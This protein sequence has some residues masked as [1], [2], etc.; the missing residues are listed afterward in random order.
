[1]PQ[2]YSLKTFLRKAC[3]GFLRPYRIG[4]GIGQCLAQDFLVNPKITPFW[5]PLCVKLRTFAQ[6]STRISETSVTQ[7]PKRLAMRSFPDM[8]D[9]L[10]ILIP[11]ATQKS[12]NPCLPADEQL[13]TGFPFPYYSSNA[14]LL[15]KWSD[16]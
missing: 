9:F 7:S 6:K 1:M 10:R 5:G 13:P 16:I 3:N 15:I 12:L 14:I 4:R 8:Y 11:G 2:K